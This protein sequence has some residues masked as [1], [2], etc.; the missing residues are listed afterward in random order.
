MTFHTG[1]LQALAALYFCSTLEETKQVFQ[2]ILESS[3]EQEARVA[4]YEMLTHYA[5][6]GVW[7]CVQ[8]LRSVLW[9]HENSVL[10]Q[11]VTD[12]TFEQALVVNQTLTVASE[13]RHV[14]QYP[15]R[16]NGCESR[17]W[18]G[19]GKLGRLWQ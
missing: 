7:D 17:H 15:E 9:Q 3:G 4:A 6:K 12:L 19:Q 13:Q 10:Y 11:K 8:L 18:Q 16:R 5:R 14:G 1:T 2:L